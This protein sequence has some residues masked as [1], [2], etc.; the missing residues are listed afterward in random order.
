MRGYGNTGAAV[1]A[2]VES[3]DENCLNGGIALRRRRTF[4]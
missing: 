4:Q 3:A 2:I 1:F